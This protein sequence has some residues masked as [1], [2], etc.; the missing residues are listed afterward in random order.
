[1]TKNCTSSQ[2]TGHRFLAA[3]GPAPLPQ[4]CQDFIGAIEHF[5]ARHAAMWMRGII[6]TFRGL[7][8]SLFLIITSQWRPH[9]ILWTHCCWYWY[10]FLRFCYGDHTRKKTKFSTQRVNIIAVFFCRTCL[11]LSFNFRSSKIW[12]LW[13]HLECTEKAGG[14]P[15]EPRSYPSATAPP[16]TTSSTSAPSDASARQRGSFFFPCRNFKHINL[17]GTRIFCSFQSYLESLT[18]RFSSLL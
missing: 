14:C 4:G 8:L 16:P 5:T 3:P 11:F 6:F 2:R 13:W 7:Y 17:K 12:T 18:S 15:R 9:F 10:Y 1:M